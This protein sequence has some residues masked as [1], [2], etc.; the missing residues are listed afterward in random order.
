MSSLV[1]VTSTHDGEQQEGTE[2]GFNFDEWI[3]ANELESV[4]QIL[5]KHKANTLSTLRFD[6]PEFQSVWTDAQLFTKPQLI[7]KLTSAVHNISKIVVADDEQKVIDC[8]KQNLKALKQTQREIEKLRASHSTSIARINASKLKQL[9]QSERK[10][11]EIFD[12]LCDILN[13][14]RQAILHD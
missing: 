12:S 3:I 14:R 1:S 10:V 2:Y 13:D 8:I 7:S 9:A 5:I 6:A 4:K 11:N